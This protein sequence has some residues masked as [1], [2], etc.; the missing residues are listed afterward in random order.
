[1]EKY[2]QKYGEL[3]GPQRFY[4][5][6][7][8]QK[9]YIEYWINTYPNDIYLAKHKFKEYTTSA[10]LNCLNYYLKNGYSKEEA[11]KL[12]S[13]HQLTNSG[14]HRSYYKKLGLPEHEITNIMNSVNK[15]KDSASLKFISSKNPELSTDEVINKYN[16]QNKYKSSTFRNNGYLRKDD[17]TLTERTMYYV[18]VNYYTERS[19]KLMTPCPGIRGKCIGEYHI[20]HKYSRYFGFENNIP[21]HIIGHISNLQWLLAQQNCSKRANCSI[22]KEDLLTEYLNYENKINK[23][24]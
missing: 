13:E 14:V 21:P 8:F 19:K 2:I 1:M 24:T 9:N 16:E 23:K 20:D 15:R 12:I 11:I 22:S 5:V 17:P 18:A 3:E 7:R 4:S 6:C 10:N